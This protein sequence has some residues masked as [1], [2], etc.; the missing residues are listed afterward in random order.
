M[1]LWKGFGARSTMQKDGRC[2]TQPAVDLIRGSSTGGKSDDSWT[3]GGRGA[4][5]PPGGWFGSQADK[6]GA[7]PMGKPR[8]TAIASAVRS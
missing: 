2:N 5:S 6:L 3:Q 1:K 7:L 8:F 4:E